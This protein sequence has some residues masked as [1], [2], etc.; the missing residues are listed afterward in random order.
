MTLDAICSFTVHEFRLPDS[1]DRDTV[2]EQ[3]RNLE[4]DGGPSI[5]LMSRIDDDRALAL[6]RAHR[7]ENGATVDQEVREIIDRMGAD[8]RSREFS[9]RVALAEPGAG[10]HFRLAMTEFGR[11][12]A[13][14]NATETWVAA[15][16]ADR[17]D[18]DSQLLWIGVT[19]DS[20]EGL[21]VLVGHDVEEQG[22][23][24]GATPRWPLPLSSEMG[25]RIYTG[26]R[27]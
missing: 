15:D 11:N 26:T 12:D 3:L 22:T 20:T 21:F 9:A 5:P 17:P 14:P 23:P 1:A 4:T 18:A 6:V 8:L 16:D 13:T 10:A 19:T 2:R 25:V 27:V 7:S 24:A